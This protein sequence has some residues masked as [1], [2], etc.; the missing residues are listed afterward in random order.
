MKQATATLVQGLMPLEPNPTNRPRRRSGDTA[1][2][3]I[4][5]AAE[6]EMIATGPA[7]I[8]QHEVA[9]EAGVGSATVPHHFQSRERLVGAVLDRANERLRQSRLEALARDVLDTRDAADLLRRVLESLRD[10]EHGR[11]RARLAMEGVLDEAQ[12]RV[13]EAVGTILHARR[14]AET[15]SGEPTEDT[16]FVLVLA[17]LALGAEPILGK[18][19]LESAGLGTDPRASYRFHEWLLELLANHLRGAQ[20][21][22]TGAGERKRRTRRRRS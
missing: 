20:A 9:A 7:G 5:D 13:L 3:A 21:A 16:L 10:R 2:Q 15:G 12:T 19:T 14:L 6:R 18:A 4:L 22:K 8:R 11:L 1:R 17:S